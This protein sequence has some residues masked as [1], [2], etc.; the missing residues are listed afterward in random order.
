[1]TNTETPAPSARA[2]AL[3]LGFVM[4]AGC[5]GNSD[6][7]ERFPVDGT[8][9]LDGSL[10]KSG[11]VTFIAQGRGAT[12]SVEVAD[13]AFHL[14][15]SDGL[16]PGPYRV[17]IFSIQP[18]GKKVPSAEDPQALIDEKINLVP[19]R[20]NVQ[21]QLKA[22]VPPGGPKEPLT[23]SLSSDPTKRAKR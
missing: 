19:K 22:E 13:G 11:T 4:A 6:G 15:N 2:L 5:G 9:T 14:G 17:E 20:Y 7:F 3:L 8:I 21:S 1:V 10:L 18:T 16:S 23:F 12:S